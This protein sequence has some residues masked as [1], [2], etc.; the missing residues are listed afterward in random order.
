MK[1][2]TLAGSSG[3]F[4]P[5]TPL[6]KSFLIGDDISNMVQLGFVPFA[7]DAPTASRMARTIDFSSIVPA[8][9]DSRGTALA[10]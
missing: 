5:G 2:L 4:I 3:M 10:P 1:K 8:L 7:D 9:F 6:P